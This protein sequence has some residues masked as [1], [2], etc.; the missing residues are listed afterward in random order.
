M[1][2]ASRRRPLNPILK[3]GLGIGIACAV[4]TFVM[5]LT[6]W[7][8]D[9]ALRN[10]FFLVVLF[11]IAGLIWGLCQTAAEGRTYGGQVVAGTL[12]SIVAGVVIVAS[13]V[14]F[15]T[16][17]YPSYF[18]DLEALQRQSLAE[19]GKP[20]AEIDATLEASRPGATPM[21]NAMQGFIGTLVTGI[22]ASAVIA[23]PV[24]ARRA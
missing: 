4:W 22:L 21:A 2:A 13:S 3:T 6:G 5:G 14:V 9:P 8:K 19:Q 12:M 11:E 16:V 10:L 15:T 20:A 17:A 24:R 7:Y 23:I 1:T 18:Q